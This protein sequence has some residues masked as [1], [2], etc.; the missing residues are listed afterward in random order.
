MLFD[1]I[2]QLFFKFCPKN[3]EIAKDNKFQK[4]C[5]KNITFL[6]QV[7]LGKDFTKTPIH[8]DRI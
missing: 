3:F 8:V 7:G 2:K 4:I 6:L 1:K 5:T